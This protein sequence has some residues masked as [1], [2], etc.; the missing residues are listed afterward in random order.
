MYTLPCAL[1]IAGLATACACQEDPLQPAPGATDRPAEASA[2]S[3]ST[4]VAP[5]PADV[6]PPPALVA[7]EQ[8]EAQFP[9][10]I[11]EWS[12]I[13][14][15]SVVQKIG[16][17]GVI[18]EVQQTRGVYQIGDGQPMIFV[19]VLDSRGLKSTH[20]TFLQMHDHPNYGITPFVHQDQPALE[21]YWPSPLN[22]V[23]MTLVSD[24]FLLIIEGEGSDQATVKKFL[25]ALDIKAIAALK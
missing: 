3:S 22:T 21:Q 5:V 14:L 19:S 8:L 20:G 25:E 4:P 10:T 17:G 18:H 11:G 2:P 1:L 16:E 15:R 23:L 12:R 24:R 7:K 9:K 13:E 6:H